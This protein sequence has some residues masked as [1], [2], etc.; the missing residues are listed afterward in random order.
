[1]TSFDNMAGIFRVGVKGV[2]TLRSDLLRSGSRLR[3]QLWDIPILSDRWFV[4]RGDAKA[5]SCVGGYLILYS[6]PEGVCL[7]IYLLVVNVCLSLSVCLL[8]HFGTY[9]AL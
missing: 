7:L 2:V 1:M 6:K 9:T 5:I 8:L 4:I 3:D